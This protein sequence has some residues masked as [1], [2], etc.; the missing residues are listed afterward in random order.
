MTPTIAGVLLVV[1]FILG[2]AFGHLRCAWHDSQIT[3]AVFQGERIEH[4]R[5]TR[6]RTTG[7][8]SD[9]LTVYAFTGL[10]RPRAPGRPKVGPVGFVWPGNERGHLC[11]ADL[12]D[13]AACRETLQLARS[14]RLPCEVLDRF[15]LVYEEFENWV[16][17]GVTR[18]GTHLAGFGRGDLP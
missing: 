11:P 3:L 8:S 5:A 6:R 4:E 17:R 16:C 7:R 15:E 12:D 10:D 18:D 14:H 2:A 1:G 13:L 9:A